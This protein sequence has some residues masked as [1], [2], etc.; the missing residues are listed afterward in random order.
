MDLVCAVRKRRL[1]AHPVAEKI[2]CR[3]R[4]GFGS[5]RQPDLIQAAL[6]QGND[7]GIRGGGQLG[8]RIAFRRI[9]RADPAFQGIPC[10]FRAYRTYGRRACGENRQQDEQLSVAGPGDVRRQVPDGHF[11]GHLLHGRLFQLFGTVLAAVLFGIQFDDAQET[12]PQGRVRPGNQPRQLGFRAPLPHPPETPPGNKH[13]QAGHGD[14]KQ[15]PADGGGRLPQSVG[16]VQERVGKNDGNACK[17]YGFQHLHRSEAAPES[18]EL[19]DQLGREF[20]GSRRG[21]AYSRIYA[22]DIVFASLPRVMK[23]IRICGRTG[24]FFSLDF[25]L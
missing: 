12:I 22:M 24:V 23:Q 18:S 11:A 14:E 6:S 10:R 13:R 7:Q 19:P 2:L 9:E 20:D 25:T 21:H 5:L 15:E 16:K 8:E 3:L 17:A 4:A 1:L